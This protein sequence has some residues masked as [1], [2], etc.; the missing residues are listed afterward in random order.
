MAWSNRSRRHLALFCG[1]ALCASACAPGP[2]AQL[3][4]VE[5]WAE[6]GRGEMFG[7]SAA[8]LGG[9]DY[10][11]VAMPFSPEPRSSQR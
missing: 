3:L 4:P 1:L 6:R 10:R 8:S 5:R 11:D 9:P 2:P 7:G